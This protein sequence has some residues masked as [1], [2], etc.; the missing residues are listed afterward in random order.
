MDSQYLKDVRILS[1]VWT[2]IA[3]L[4]VGLRWR[5]RFSLSFSCRAWLNFGLIY[6]IY[7]L[8]AIMSQ[9]AQLIIFL[10]PVSI[11]GPERSYIRLI[12]FYV[13]VWSTRISLLSLFVASTPGRAE[14]EFRKEFILMIP[15]YTLIMIGLIIQMA[16]V[17]H[18]RKGWEAGELPQ[19]PL[20]RQ[21]AISHYVADG[22]ADTL[23]FYKIISILRHLTRD[24]WRMIGSFISYPSI[25]CASVVHA[26][27]I[28][29]GERAHEVIAGVVECGICILAANIPFVVRGFYETF[30]SESPIVMSRMPELSIRSAEPR[31]DSSIELNDVSSPQLSPASAMSTCT[32]LAPPSPLSTAPNSTSSLISHLPR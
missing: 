29:R 16:V 28:L 31:D 1:A 12:T 11:W 14:P 6:E 26:T 22:I 30:G 32:H 18:I 24:K 23:V 20:G 9:I 21:V 15:V 8:L 10:L 25:I 2:I 7:T 4:L 5:F 13:I 17:C 27:F 19:C 3:I